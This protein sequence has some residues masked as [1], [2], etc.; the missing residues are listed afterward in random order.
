MYLV[1]SLRTF[2][3][4]STERTLT[5][6]ESFLPGDEFIETDTDTIYIH[7][8]MAW[9][10]NPGGSP[11]GSDTQIQFNDDG[12]FGASANLTFNPITNQMLVGG[13]VAAGVS[14]ALEVHDS[15]T[16]MRFNV[17][18]DSASNG[19]N[20]TNVG[21]YL[22]NDAEEF[23]LSA[24]WTAG[25]ADRTDGSE[26]S[27]LTVGLIRNGLNAITT[28]FGAS[29]TYFN[30]NSDNIDTI[31]YGANESFTTMVDAGE[32][33]FQVGFLTPGNIVDF[34]YAGI[35]FNNGENDI[36]FRIA[37]NGVTNG[38]FYD[39]GTNRFGIGTATPQK[40]FHVIEN[41]DI[42]AIFENSASGAQANNAFY[43]PD[44][45]DGNES[46][47]AFQTDTT[48]TG[49]TTQAAVAQIRGVFAV[50]NHATRTANITFNT[51]Q[52]GSGLVA[53][54]TIGAGIIVG[55]P[56]G[57]DKGAGTLNAT[58]VYDDNVLL[59]DYVFESDYPLL[60]IDS[61][62]A[63]YETNKHLPTIPG[64]DEWEKDGKFSLGKLVNHLWET[65]EVQAIYISQLHKRLEKLEHGN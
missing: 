50:H 48:G 10:L 55:S 6:L 39:A 20:L 4:T 30:Y 11:G 21:F 65:V 12:V 58:A 37:G 8:G 24:F 15:I 46:I 33:A 47:L 1:R 49:A 23:T 36:N 52:S 29:Q 2:I 38:V 60:T 27:Y 57:G 7:N 22:K 18:N 54:L 44:T 45:T 59:T 64:R 61:M 3:G 63:F 14:S 19:S 62:M 32:N 5:P 53:R 42:P 56:T 28:Y 26:D 51:R 35:V 31:I 25:L 34:R 13:S 17:V 16:D 40:R 41:G 43:H 9:L